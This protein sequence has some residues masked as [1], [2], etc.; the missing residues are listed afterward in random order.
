MLHGNPEKGVCPVTIRQD[1]S[2][3]TQWAFFL[4]ASHM[5]ILHLGQLKFSCFGDRE[6]EMHPYLRIVR[7]DSILV[8]I[9]QEQGRKKK[10]L[11]MNLKKP[12]QVNICKWNL[13]RW[14]RRRNKIMLA[15]H[16]YICAKLIFFL[17]ASLKKKKRTVITASYF[18]IQKKWIIEIFAALKWFINTYK[19]FFSW[20][21]IYIHFF[22]REK[23]FL[24]HSLKNYLTKVQHQG[25]TF[26]HQ[27]CSHFSHW[28]R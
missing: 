27:T 3:Q 5:S 15:F 10:P 17:C 26:C 4:P 2:T 18:H 1:L 7:L 6:T 20:N 13:Y 25:E 28:S 23:K 21:I 8:T 14:G 9:I 16:Q 11:V 22:S 24:G 19:I 12:F